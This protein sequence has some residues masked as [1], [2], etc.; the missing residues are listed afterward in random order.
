MIIRSFKRNSA[1]YLCVY[2]K[3]WYQEKSINILV[4][5]TI[6]R[7]RKIERPILN[8]SLRWGKIRL[9][10]RLKIESSEFENIVTDRGINASCWVTR[11]NR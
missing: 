10:D 8:R 6:V 5:C 9:P 11:N 7:L 3:G 1:M 2:L 4:K